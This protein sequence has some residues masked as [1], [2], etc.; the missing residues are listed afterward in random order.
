MYIYISPLE[1]RKHFSRA[2]WLTLRFGLLFSLP[3]KTLKMKKK[4]LAACQN[5]QNA[6]KRT[7]SNRIHAFLETF[8]KNLQG[9]YCIIMICFSN[10]IHRA[11]PEASFFGTLIPYHCP[12]L[13]CSGP[14]LTFASAEKHLQGARWQ[15][16]PKDSW[17]KSASCWSR[18]GRCLEVRFSA[19]WAHWNQRNSE[20]GSDF[21]LLLEH[22]SRAHA[23]KLFHKI[24]WS[25]SASCWIRAGR[26]LEAEVSAH[27]GHWNTRKSESCWDF[28]LL[29]EH[30]S[31]A[32]AARLFEKIWWWKSAFCWSSAGWCLKIRVSV[33][34]DWCKINAQWRK[35]SVR[36]KDCWK[37]IGRRSPCV[38]LKTHHKTWERC[39]TCSAPL[40]ICTAPQHVINCCDI[41]RVRCQTVYLIIQSFVLAQQPVLNTDKFSSNVLQ[42]ISL[43]SFHIVVKSA[44]NQSAQTHR[45][46]TFMTRKLQMRAR[47]NQPE[48]NPHKTLHSQRGFASEK[49]CSILQI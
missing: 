35:I 33:R 34:Q 1:M 26:C 30:A 21:F 23:G 18:A 17:W 31:R 28:F 14:L 36:L 48:I 8:K 9:A 11:S 12:T 42:Q 49:H 40:P 32:P 6:S 13:Y 25:K 24:K 16:F 39:R 7:V 45:T 10:Q 2:T 46:L 37:K 3:P 27:S 47:S 15:G 38:E 44:S 4:W 43:K 5:C 41:L 20:L 29:L 22:T 19:L